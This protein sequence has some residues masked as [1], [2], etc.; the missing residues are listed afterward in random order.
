[1]SFFGTGE[2]AIVK[3]HDTPAVKDDAEVLRTKKAETRMAANRAGPGRTMN[4]LGQDT[5][6]AN[7]Q[8][9]RLLGQ[10]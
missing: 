3:W 9:A 4:M 6:A 1:M 8:R 2:K 10:A 5:G 7:T